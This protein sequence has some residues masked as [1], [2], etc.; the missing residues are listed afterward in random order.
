MEIDEELA[1]KAK[2]WLIPGALLMAAALVLALR[3][4]SR[5]A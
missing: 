1:A 4:K 2:F 5:A 3:R